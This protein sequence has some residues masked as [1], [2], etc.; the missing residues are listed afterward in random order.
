V[1]PGLEDLSGD[2]VFFRDDA[3]FHTYSREAAKSSSASTGISM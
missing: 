2:S 3:I 1:N